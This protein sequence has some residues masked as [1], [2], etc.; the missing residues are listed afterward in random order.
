MPK[1]INKYIEVFGGAF[2]VYLRSDFIAKDVVYNDVNPF[3]ANLFACCTEYDKFLEYIES[4]EAQDSELFNK[5]REEVVERFGT[6]DVEIPDFDL[7]M[8]YA[9]VATQTFSGIIKP[10]SKMIDLKGKYKPKYYSLRD[11]L[12][13]KKIREKLD[14]IRVTNLSYEDVFDREDDGKSWIYLDPPYFGTEDL[15]GFHSF[16]KEDHRNLVSYLKESNSY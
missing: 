6:N 11:R 3:M 5:F 9:Y 12:R 7:G 2:W 16:N 10:N 4:C 13:N 14:K 8:K 1:Q 15:Y